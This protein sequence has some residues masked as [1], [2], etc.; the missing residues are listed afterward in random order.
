[1][2]KRKLVAKELNAVI[3]EI[4][5]TGYPNFENDD[6]VATCLIIFSKKMR[7]IVEIFEEIK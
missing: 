3:K 6:E 7:T 1:M 4:E 2:E 5:G